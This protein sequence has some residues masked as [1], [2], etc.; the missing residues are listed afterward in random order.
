MTRL[1]RS[2]PLL[3]K[4]TTM[5]LWVKREIAP[6]P[7]GKADG[8]VGVNGPGQPEAK[9]SP[10]DEEDLHVADLARFC[11]PDGMP[12]RGGDVLQV[13]MNGGDVVTGRA[14]ADR[15]DHRRVPANQLKLLAATGKGRIS[16]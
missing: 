9:I 12:G 8:V 6:P 11:Y 14:A 3:V 7:P 4:S 10:G 16:E 13:G 5:V 2:Q 15:Y 1:L